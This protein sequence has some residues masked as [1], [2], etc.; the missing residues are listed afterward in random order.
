MFVGEIYHLAFVNA[1]GACS[2]FIPEERE[3]DSRCVSD[4]RNLSV[5]TVT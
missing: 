5:H 1:T 2:I 4:E 3:K